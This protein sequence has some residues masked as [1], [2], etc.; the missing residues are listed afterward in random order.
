MTIN[1][2]AHQEERVVF[3]NPSGEK[4]LGILL[5]AGSSEAAILCH[6]YTDHKNGFHLPAIARALADRGWSSFR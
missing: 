4:L 6:G 1:G 2:V 3:I 5:D